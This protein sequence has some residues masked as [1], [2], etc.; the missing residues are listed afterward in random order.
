M[1]HEGKTCTRR[2]ATDISQK[3][4][5]IMDALSY[6]REARGSKLH[7]SATVTAME[8][9]RRRRICGEADMSLVVSLE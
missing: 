7:L 4:A 8:R 5:T 1:Y 3:T 2:Y 9:R 6:A